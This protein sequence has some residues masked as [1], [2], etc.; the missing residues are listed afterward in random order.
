MLPLLPGHSSTPDLL[1][2]RK[3]LWVATYLFA[4]RGGSKVVQRSKL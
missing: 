4:V 1:A 2:E 3:A